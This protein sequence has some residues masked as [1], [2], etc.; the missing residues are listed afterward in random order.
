MNGFRGTAV[1]ILTVGLVAAAAV[2]AKDSLW[3]ANTLDFRMG[4]FLGDFDTDVTLGGPNAEDEINLEDDL[5]LETDQTTFRGE[6]SWRFA[7]RH[8]LGLAYYEFNRSAT[9]TAQRTFVIDTDD[10]T[11]R[12]DVEATVRTEFDWRLIPVT[13]TYS[14]VQNERFEGAATVGFHWART[15]IA[16]EGTALVN[17]TGY[18]NARETETTSVPLPVLG[19]QGDVAL[20][21][22][23][24]LGARAQWF[25]LDYDDYSGDLFDARITTEYR[26]ADTV[27]FGIGYTWYRLDLTKHESRWKYAVEYEYHGPEAYMTVSF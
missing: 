16:L 15:K 2:E 1:V 8:R 25:G 27:G 14:L 7:D 4:A 21:P 13:Y 24:R 20:T 12:F 11:L 26:F 6:F 22:D 3:T 17:D 5:G 9:G 23:W 19:L 10:Q 18:G